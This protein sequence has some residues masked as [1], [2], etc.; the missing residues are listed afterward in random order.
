MDIDFLN[1]NYKNCLIITNKN[2]KNLILK[3]AFKSSK[4][5]KFKLVDIN[6][7]QTLFLPYVNPICEYIIYKK[8][9]NRVLAKNIYNTLKYIKEEEYTFY[10]LK[11]IKEIYD[12]L[13]EKSYIK[14][15]PYINDFKQIISTESNLDYLGINI[16]YIDYDNKDFEQKKLDILEFSNINDEIF[17]TLN[18]VSKLLKE[19]VNFSNIKIYAPNLYSDNILLLSKYFNIDFKLDTSF[20]IKAYNLVNNLISFMKKNKTCDVFLYEHFEKINVDIKN[21]I[22]SVINKNIE[23]YDFDYIISEI[24]DINISN[25]YIKDCLEINNILNFDY[26]KDNY[27]FILGFDNLNFISILK[28][29]KYL[30][31]NELRQLLRATS[32][33][34]NNNNVLKLNNIMKFVSNNKYKLTYSKKVNSLETDICSLIDNKFLNIINIDI[35]KGDQYSFN[36]DKLLFKIEEDKFKKYNIKSN[37]YYILKKNIKYTSFI[38]NNMSNIN[39]NF[40][41]FKSSK[42]ISSTMLES[43][44][45]CPFSF[46]IKY[47]LNIHKPSKNRFNIDLG[48]YIHD[49]LENLLLEDKTNIQNLSEQ[50]IKRNNLFVGIDNNKIN[51]IVFKVLNYVDEL[52]NI[53]KSQIDNEDFKV[54]SL[55]EEISCKFFDYNLVGKIDKVLKFDDKYMVIDYKT[56]NDSLSFDNLEM[57]FN[58]QNLIYFILLKSKYKDVEFAGTYRYKITPKI[59]DKNKFSLPKRNGYTSSDK[60]ILS[61]I[62]QEN[63]KNL[64]LSGLEPSKTS[65]V[66][67]NQEYLDDIE[68]VKENIKKFIFEIEN[69]KVF[70]IQD[71][72]IKNEKISCKYCDYNN[73]CFKSKKDILYK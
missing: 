33:E 67:T 19:G 13:K 59:V 54:S 21:K 72:V 17:Y 32:L 47:V 62:D 57:G 8:I 37:D 25:I 20:N 55:E 27:N 11:N 3:N 16:N 18:E 14:E 53:I 26:N 42:K 7:A 1:V 40:K 48:I 46:Y 31:D 23:F 68:I 69:K 4:I 39:W 51:F 71:L 38:S 12:F 66:L 35:I 65:K 50:I 60:D 58:M 63:Y 36:Y 52:I 34:E 73:I 10:K 5:L 43:Y 24:E 41:E 2:T 30:N 44:F 22:L 6:E 29:D 45:K 70:K 61:K 9:N 28:D 15:K 56:G 49:I 64:K